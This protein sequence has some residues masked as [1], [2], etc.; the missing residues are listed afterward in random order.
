[1]FTSNEMKEMFEEYEASVAAILVDL[2]GETTLAGVASCALEFEMRI[3]R[4]AAKYELFLKSLD[5]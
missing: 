2:A 1:M 5:Q 4:F 3:D